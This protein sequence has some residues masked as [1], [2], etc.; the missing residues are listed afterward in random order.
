[1]NQGTAEHKLPN[2]KHDGILNVCGF[3]IPYWRINSSYRN[4]IVYSLMLKD[5]REITISVL[6]ID[7][8][9]LSPESETG[10]QKRHSIDPFK[11]LWN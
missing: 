3:K 9:A 6:D 4:H 10:N 1:M 11:R 7:G 5:E 2:R 8:K